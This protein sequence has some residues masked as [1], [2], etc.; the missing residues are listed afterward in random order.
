[1]TLL[2]VIRH[3]PTEWNE[4]GVVQ[5]HSDIPL[6][7]SGRVSVSAW[8]PPRDLDIFDWVASP[9]KRAQ[10]TAVILSGRRPRTDGRLTEMNWAVWEGKRLP[11]LRAELGD[12]MK[13][14]EAKGLDFRAPGGE[15][16]RDV[17]D[18][19]KPFLA[20]CAAKR[21]DTVAV[22][23]KGV[24]RALYALSVS[25]DMTDKAPEK[26]HDECVHYFRL[27]SNGAPT[28]HRLNQPMTDSPTAYGGG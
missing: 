7:A 5:G 17:Q 11:E 26:L 13:A 20:E 16:P 4:K 14:W 22:C 6:S 9:L 3:G 2:A 27:D 21:Q 8:T 19:L 10:E 12:L 24:L 18:R 25:W 15:S 23:H 1:M 28:P